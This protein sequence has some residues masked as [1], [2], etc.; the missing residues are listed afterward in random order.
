MDANVDQTNRGAPRAPTDRDLLDALDLIESGLADDELVA[1]LGPTN[2]REHD[3]A[4]EVY[5]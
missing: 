3:Y 2:E 5:A 1:E 4:R